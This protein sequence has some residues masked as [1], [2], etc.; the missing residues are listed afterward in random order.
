MIK[1]VITQRLE[2][3]IWVKYIK[4]ISFKPSTDTIYKN[5]LSSLK[6]ND[7]EK[8][9]SYIITIL[10]IDINFEPVHHLLTLLVFSLS[11]EFIKNKGHNIKSKNPDLNKYLSS[12]EKQ[13]SNCEREIIVAQNNLSKTEAKVKE[14][15]SLNNLFKKKTNEEQISLLKNEILNNSEKL[16]KLRK[17]L[18]TAIELCKI[19]EYMKVS[20]LV[21][22]IVHNQK[23][24]INNLK[25]TRI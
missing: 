23:K 2:K 17:D 8:A 9:I 25:I 4:E 21:L 22:E 1:D 16:F 20:A 7:T 12:I 15:F 13:I 3:A 6:D 24:F 5:I 18:N 10:E 19:E 14:G 11:E